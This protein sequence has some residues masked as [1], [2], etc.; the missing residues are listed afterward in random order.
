MEARMDALLDRSID[1]GK[2]S[3]S[4]WRQETE[5]WACTRSEQMRRSDKD[6]ED[7]AE[8]VAMILRERRRAASALVP[9][10]RNG[11]RTRSS[12]LEEARRT[13]SRRAR[14]FWAGCLPNFF[15]QDSGGGIDQTD[16]ICLP[17]LASFMSL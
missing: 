2:R 3:R 9:L 16:F 8:S 14:G 11:S 4:K 13:R 10:P 7:T 15:S 12:S 17:A 6:I 5:I 1:R